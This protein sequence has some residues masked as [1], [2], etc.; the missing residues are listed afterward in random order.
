M[1]R[2]VAFWLALALALAQPALAQTAPTAAPKPSPTKPSSTKPTPAKPAAK[3]PEPPKPDAAAEHGPCI[4]VIPHIGESFQVQK[5]GLFSFED[6]H[7]PI[8]SWGLDDLVVGRVRAAAGAR[9]VVR[10]IAYPANAPKPYKSLFH[11]PEDDIKAIVQTIAHAGECERY[12]VVLRSGSQFATTRYWVE[13]VGILNAP[14][15]T[16]LEGAT[17]LFALTLLYVVDGRTFAVLKK[18]VGSIEEDDSNLLLNGLS[19]KIPLRGPSREL[20]DFSWPP[21][22]DAVMGLRDPARALLAASLDKILPGLLT[23]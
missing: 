20:K 17:Y 2:N 12:I 7:V 22:P 4:G 14:S 11:D 8:D 15:I 13:G 6:K 10:G 9:F 16:N 5:I 1:I 19:H 18:A 3:K 21:A 23:P